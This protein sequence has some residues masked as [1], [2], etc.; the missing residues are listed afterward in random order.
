MDLINLNKKA[1]NRI[2]G[3]FS[4]TRGQ[5]WP[6]F[7]EFTAYLKSGQR[8]LDWGCGN[9]RLVNMLV[10]KKIEYFGVDQ[11]AELL[12]HARRL[13]AAE[14]KS[15]SAHFYN[16]ANKPKKF[17]E[18]YFD[19]YFLIASF[20]HLPNISSRQKLL[21]QAFLELKP[22]GLLYISVWN[23]GSDWANK[24]KSGWKQ[25]DKDDYLI[26]WKDPTGKVL[27]ERFYHHFTKPELT[28]L[29]TDAGFKITKSYYSSF[30]GRTDD[31]GGRNLIVF[32]T[33]PK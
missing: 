8:V 21:R 5:A 20:F 19:I 27:A 29:I 30:A 15:G 1:Y 6:E 31:K 3:H 28:D 2:A 17:P 7:K 24:K 14:L 4:S 11:S 33:K 13:H 22:G 16:I 25:L 23:L 26:P 10:G 12:K 32:A 18:N 9:G